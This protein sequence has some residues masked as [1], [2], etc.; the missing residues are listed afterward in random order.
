MSAA[1]STLLYVLDTGGRIQKMPYTGTA[2]SSAEQTKDAFV[3]GHMILAR[4]DSVN[5]KTSDWVMVGD[6][7]AFAALAPVTWSKDQY[8]TYGYTA[9]PTGDR[10]RVHVAFDSMFETNNTIYIGFD[11]L[12]LGQGGVYR[13][14]IGKSSQ[15]DDL[16]NV[17]TAFGT[18]HNVGIYGLMVAFTGAT[19][20][21]PSGGTLK[22]EGAIYAAHQLALPLVIAAGP[23]AVITGGAPAGVDRSVEPL[24]GVPKP[25]ITWDCLNW[26]SRQPGLC[27]AFA[28]T[29]FGTNGL[30]QFTEEPWSLKMCGCLTV[31]TNTTLFEIDNSNPYMTYITASSPACPGARGPYL[32][33]VW[34]FEDC[35]AKKGPK[36][37]MADKALVGCDPVSGRNQEINFTWEQLCIAVGYDIEIAK[38][39]AWTLRVFDWVATGNPFPSAPNNQAAP[40]GFQPSVLTSPA[41]IFP[42]AGGAGAS[43][44][45]ALGAGGV[46]SLVSTLECGHTYY[47]RVEV[48]QCATGQIVRSPWSEVRSFTIKAGLPVS[49]PYYGLQLLAPDNGCIGCPV[50]PVSFSWSPY[51]ET[52]KYEFVLSQDPAMTKVVVTAQTATTG[53]EYEAGLDYGQNYFW[54]VRSVEPAPSDWSA[55]FS[56]MTAA[57]PAPPAPAPTAP[58][59]PI[60]VWVVIAIGAIL[61]IVTLVLIFKTRRV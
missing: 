6:N 57:A 11:G 60:W 42:T 24:S 34:M 8:N 41:F 33:D 10:G 9:T 38:D 32:G 19:G 23:P 25:G 20:I 28:G 48:R 29:T 46:P 51:K 31:D 50:K 27:N 58:P 22:G 26:F 4:Y 3:R 47:W 13:F 17:S 49:M 18:F 7:A 44:W 52:T 2:W 61:V 45:A 16:M 54:R 59:T 56:F 21:A 15:W 53:Y 40:F 5:K 30:V 39:P 37:T 12:G 35:M 14:A 43:G 55:T 36:L 1:S